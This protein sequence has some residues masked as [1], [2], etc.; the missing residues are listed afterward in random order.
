MPRPSDDAVV[1]GAPTPDPSVL[2]DELDRV[3]QKRLLLL[4]EVGMGED[5]L[6]HVG[7]VLLIGRGGAS[8]GRVAGGGGGPGGGSQVEKPLR[9][10]WA[11]ETSLDTGE[12][13]CAH[14]DGLF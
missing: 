2:A 13:G 14:P 7:G 12:V 4:G 11:N 5:C 9:S 3:H 6:D 8:R 1:P 10:W